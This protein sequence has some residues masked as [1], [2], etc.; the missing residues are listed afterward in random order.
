MEHWLTFRNRVAAV[1]RLTEALQIAGT[2]AAVADAALF[3]SNLRFFLVT[4][5]MIPP[6]A[7]AD[8]RSLYADLTRRLGEAGDLPAQE[9]DRIRRYLLG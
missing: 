2:H 9:A 8:E 3:Y 4:G 1:R 5:F 6:M 7:N